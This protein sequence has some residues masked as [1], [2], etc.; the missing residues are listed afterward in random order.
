[1]NFQ[2]RYRT[3]IMYLYTPKVQ[4]LFNKE[5]TFGLDEEAP[6]IFTFRKSC[7]DVFQEEEPRLPTDFAKLVKLPP[8]KR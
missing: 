4:D 8:F 3:S 6:E 7:H 5:F 2:E 1:M